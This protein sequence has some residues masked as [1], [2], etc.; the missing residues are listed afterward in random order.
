M[1]GSISPLHSTPLQIKLEQH[2]QKPDNSQ[3]LSFSNF[4]RSLPLSNA[5]TASVRP[6]APGRE[7]GGHHGQ[8]GG[9]G[10]AEHRGFQEAGGQS[11]DNVGVP[12][13]E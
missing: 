12:G 5:T 11:G 4:L 9:G 2:S 8:V 7:G 6:L 13:R 1:V 3:V 10:L